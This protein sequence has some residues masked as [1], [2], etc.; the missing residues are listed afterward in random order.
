[1]SDLTVR[2]SRQAYD[3]SWPERKGQILRVGGV[4]GAILLFIVAIEV[5]RHR[6]IGFGTLDERQTQACRLAL[7][8][9]AG[10]FDRTLS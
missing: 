5:V 2:P 10:R 8:T 7:V 1:M 4:A 3:A 9:A 6:R